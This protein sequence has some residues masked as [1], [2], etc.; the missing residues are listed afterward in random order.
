[1][2]DAY[3]HEL[4][5]YIHHLI[6]SNIENCLFAWTNIPLRL[7]VHAYVTKTQIAQNLHV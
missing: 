6:D 7:L 4:Y 1:M 2:E 5:V 3:D